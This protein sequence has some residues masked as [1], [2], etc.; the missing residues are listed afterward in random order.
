[1]RRTADPNCRH[2]RKMLRLKLWGRKLFWCHDCEAF[3]WDIPVKRQLPERAQLAVYLTRFKTRRV[4]ADHIGVHFNTIYKWQA[5]KEPIP[6]WMCAEL[7]RRVE[8]GR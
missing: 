3:T 6:A 1:M 7:N 8:L 5:G 4:A 2:S